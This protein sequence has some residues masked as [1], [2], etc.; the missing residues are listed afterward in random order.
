MNRIAT[1]KNPILDYS[2]GSRSA[3]ADLLGQPSPS[4]GPQAELWMGAHPKAPSTL[5]WENR[6]IALPELISRYPT[7]I[8]GPDATRRFNGRLPYLF[9]V[10]AAAQPLSIQAH[11]DRNQAA[12]G[13]ERENVMGIPLDAPHRNYRDGN[14]KPECICALTPF[15]GLNGFR[16]ID[17]MIEYFR[18]LDVSCL[19]SEL[20]LLQSGNIKGFFESLMTMDELR[21]RR[22]TAEVGDLARTAEADDPVFRWI[23]SLARVHPN[24]IG[25]LAPILLNLVCLRPGQA[26]FLGSGE[27]HAYLEGTGVELMANSDN[28]LRGGLTPKH[29]D[30]PELLRVVNFEQ[31]RIDVLE[32]EPVGP[33]E[34]R[35]A[36]RAEEFV[37]SVIDVTEKIPHQSRKKRSVEILLC[38][39]GRLRVTDAGQQLEVEKGTSFL[40]PAAAPAYRIEGAGTLYK[41]AVPIDRTD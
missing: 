10:L 26:M 12:R 33:S 28:V 2:W 3:I 29:I 21:K 5:L 15:W 30:V 36:C 17:D 7:E 40:V 13:F 19:E 32:P 23:N 35:Y 39:S 4:D 8:L 16:R 38:T 34:R 24:D 37:L 11:P 6:S 27:L 9:K 25:I 18:R 41:A 22:V 20:A 31:R 1:L 14:H